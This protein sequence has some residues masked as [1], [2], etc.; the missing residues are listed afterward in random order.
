M[1]M[2]GPDDRTDEAAL[3]RRW[4]SA[5][6]SGAAAAF[7]PDAVLLAAYAEDR[8]PEAMSG[9]IED[10]LVAHPE[11]LSDILAARRA[12]RAEGPAAPDAMI[13][14]AAALVAPGDAQILTFPQPAGRRAGWRTAAMW[15]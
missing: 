11:T 7:E 8:L 9:T 3:W 14:R 6:A 2:A 5:S 10:W 13:A 15:S 4:R 1:V 12:A